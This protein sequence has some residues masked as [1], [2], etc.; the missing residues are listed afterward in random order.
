[1][2]VGLDK[3]KAVHFGGVELSEGE[4]LGMMKL[5]YFLLMG[6]QP[7]ESSEVGGYP[8][9]SMSSISSSFST[10]SRDSMESFTGD[11]GSIFRR[12][13]SSQV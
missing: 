8:H 7:P 2:L 13:T 5:V 1:L 10:V 12:Q 3:Y 9:V 11:G 4:F 6:M